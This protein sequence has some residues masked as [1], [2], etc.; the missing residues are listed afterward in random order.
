MDQILTQ[1]EELVRKYYDDLFKNQPEEVG[2]IFLS[3]PSYD[4]REAIGAIRTILGGWI[5]QGPNVKKFESSFS[6]Y[7]GGTIGVAVNSGSSA[8]LL[9]IHALKEVYGLRDGDEVIVPAATFSTVAMPLIQV[10]L[11]PVYVDVKRDSLNMAPSQIDG[12]I[13]DKSRVLMPVHTLGYPA[14]MPALVEIA[15]RHKLIVFEDCCEAHGSTINGKKVGSFGEIA[16]FSYFVAHNMTTGEGGM[17]VTNNEKLE[18]TCRSLRE[19]GRINQKNVSES[20]YYNDENLKDYDRRYVF[21]RI[22]YNLRMT[23]ITAAFGIEQLAKLDEMNNQRR[24][25][26]DFLIKILSS[27]AKEFL[28]LPRE[29][30]G[31]VHTYYTFPMVL[32]EGAPFSRREFSEHLEAN[33]IE[34]RPLFAG[35]LPDQPAFQGVSGRVVGDL[36]VSRYLRDNLI[37]IGVHP[38]LKNKHLEYV[39]G[40]ILNFIKE[41]AK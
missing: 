38:G 37:F 31:Y 19:F 40:T 29:Q 23:D 9:A 12:A 3:E 2:K 24:A 20:R 5:S 8:N 32:K 1:I 25:N 22:G 11:V 4:S 35:C 17:I 18:E 36:E 33:N 28:E 10:G 6:K 34:T 41:R 26:A 27:E 15:K 21:D 14:E 30:E 39:A 16:S 7:I 13:S